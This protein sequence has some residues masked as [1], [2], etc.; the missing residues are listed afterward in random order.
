M[1]ALATQRSDLT[2]RIGE[3][4]DALTN[5]RQQLE[6][7]RL[8]MSRVDDLEARRAML[9]AEVREL[10]GQKQAALTETS[11]AEAE[12]GTKRAEL[13]DLRAQITVTQAA[14]DA[15]RLSPDPAVELSPPPET[16]PPP[17]ITE[18]EDLP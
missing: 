6:A 3:E 10:N 4:R 13:A 1:A 16:T 5:I 8:I 9:D 15:L 14:R 7:A 12:L 11:E 18:E 17:A 2:T